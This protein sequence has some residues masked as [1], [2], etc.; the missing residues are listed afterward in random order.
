MLSFSNTDAQIFCNITI[1]QTDQLMADLAAV[2]AAHKRAITGATHDN[3]AQA[4]RRWTKNCS[5][6]GYDDFYLNGLGRQEQ[7][8]ILGAFGMALRE[9]RFSTAKH[10]TLVERTIRGTTSHDH[11]FRMKGRPNP[12]KDIDNKLS[13]L[14]SRQYHT[15]RNEDPKEK[16]QKALHSQS[17]TNKQNNKWANLT[18]QLHNYL[19]EQLSLPAGP[20][21]TLRFHGRN[22][23]EWSNY[24]YKILGFSKL[25]ISF[26]YLQIVCN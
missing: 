24:A 13:I 5:S 21:N 20:A 10:D 22:W 2:A 4:W 8:L 1:S 15:Y 12:T 6:I 19:S 25:G 14:L 17:L 11:A 9:G 26:W 18:R 23:R 16:Q 7:I 3:A